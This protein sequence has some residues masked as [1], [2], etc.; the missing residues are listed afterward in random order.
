M[1]GCGG[2]DEIPKTGYYASPR[3]LFQM[4][5]G[6]P[7]ENLQP[8]R[9]KLRRDTLYVTYNGVARIDL[10]TPEL[11]PIGSISL[12]DPEPIYPT[13]LDVTDS[14]LVV[15]DLRRRMVVFYDHAGKV[16]ESFGT[17]P[18]GGQLAPFAV[19]AFGG[20]AYISDLNMHR[21]LAVSMVDVDNL[22]ERGEL[23][24]TIPSD[25]TLSI[26]FPSMLLVT[27]DGRLIVGDAGD[28]KINVFTCDGRYIYDFDSVP[29]VELVGPMAIDGDNV[30]DPD[31]QDS[32][33]FD[34]SGLPNMGRFHVVDVNNAKI[35]MFNPVGKYVSSYPADDILKRPAGIAI[36]RKRHRIM[37]ADPAA[38]RI[39]VFGY[40]GES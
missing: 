19:T 7:E 26:D 33:K 30:I 35:H 2:S 18:E 36:D 28:S 11:K 38:G 8:S 9:L 32:T 5:P 4:E 12:D 14:E 17:L 13:S 37:I 34:P 40:E 20:V 25:S 3:L 24:L 21:V 39:F 10:F 27:P 16:I 23:I 15:T 22:T 6:Q 1:T 29:A 31:L